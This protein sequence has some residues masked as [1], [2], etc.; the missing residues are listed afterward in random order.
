MRVMSLRKSLDQPLTIRCEAREFEEEEEGSETPDWTNATV[1]WLM[2][3]ERFCPQL[4]PKM[5]GKEGDSFYDAPDVFLIFFLFFIF[6]FLFFIFYFLFF[7]FYFLFFIFYFLFFIFYFSFFIF[8]FL[9]FI[10]Y[11]VFFIF[12]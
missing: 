8:Y 2:N 11:F 12:F 9:F 7:I 10:F 6:Y 1:K 4:L 5:K 3:H